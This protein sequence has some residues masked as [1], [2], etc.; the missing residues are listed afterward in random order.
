MITDLAALTI[1][2]IAAGGFGL[3]AGG[4]A[5]L[6]RKGARLHRT[7]GN[8]FFVSMLLMSA[9]G[10]SLAVL[11]PAAAAFNVVI[12]TLTFYLVA[13]AWATVLREERTVGAFER[14]AFGAAV[15]IGAGGLV[16]GF[17][18]ARSA[19]G[20]TSDGI[21]A[22]LYFF[23]GGAALLAAA[24]DASVILRR[25]VSGAQRIAR[26]LWRMCFALLIASIAFFI[27]QGA[28]VF[29]LPVREAKIFF[30]PVLAVPVILVLVMMLFWL[31]RVLATR[32][33]K[34]SAQMAPP[35]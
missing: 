34:G 11:K 17:L 31:V 20:S 6:A 35:R 15:A 32:W 12:A 18:A 7:A 26:H 23:F 1:F 5:L 4:T 24:L 29:P 3:A 10:A 21:P 33:Y 16:L 30:L 25:G 9:S 2:H 8:V 14:S 22:F 19:S 28:K 27:G 13:T